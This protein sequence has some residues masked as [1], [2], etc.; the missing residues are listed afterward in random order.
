MA[1]SKNIDSRTTIEYDAEDIE[2]T[3]ANNN[4]IM[5]KRDAIEKLVNEI[6]T[7]EKN[8]DNNSIKKLI[9]LFQN[10]I[11]QIRKLASSALV[12]INKNVLNILD[13]TLY[14]TSFK[15]EDTLYWSLQTAAG[16][17]TASAEYVIKWASEEN[18]PKKYKPILAKTLSKINNTA[19][20]PF[21]IEL[22]G[23]DNWLTRKEAAA[24]LT[25][26]GRNI[27]PQL[28]SSFTNE[29][30]E[31]R[32]W[33]A[34]IIGQ[35]LG[36]D[37]FA[38]FKNM[39]QS[40]RRE[41]RYYAIS[42][43]SE[44]SEPDAYNAIASKVAD[45]SWLIRVQS[46]DILEKLGETAIPYLQKI[47]SEGTSDEKFYAIKILKNITKDNALRI[48]KESINTGDNDSKILMLS[49]LYDADEDTVFGMLADSLTDHNYFIQ[50]HASN[51]LIQMGC[52][53]L[54]KITELFKKTQNENLRYWLI[55]VLNSFAITDSFEAI[56]EIFNE[57][58]KRE[59]IQIL[60]PLSATFDIALDNK[61]ALFIIKALKDKS[62]SVRNCAFT[63]LVRFGYIKVNFNGQPESLNDIL[64]K[65]QDYGL[66]ESENEHIEE[67]VR[68]NALKLE[69]RPETK[70][71]AAYQNAPAAVTQKPIYTDQPQLSTPQANFYGQLQPASEQ[72]NFQTT[73]EL[74]I[75]KYNF[76]ID[77][78]LKDAISKKASDIHFSVNYPPSFRIDGNVEFQKKYPELTPGNTRYLAYQVMK[79]IIRNSFEKI[80]EL[81]ISYEIKGTARFRVN[82][83]MDMHG[84]GMVF[85]VIPY[86]IPSIETLGAPPILKTL[87][88]KSKGLVL[89]TG[90]TGSGKSTTLA[91]MIN[92]INKI[93]KAHII[94]IE[95]PVEFV[96]SPILSKITQRE[97]NVST[98]SF[99][100]ALRSSLRE[101][102]D[103]ILV[104]EMRDLE[105]IELAITA[106]ET[107]H[108][109]FG[110]V[111]TASAANTID[112]IIDVFPADKHSQVR[113]S[114]V[115]GLLAVIAQS[116][117]PKKNGHGR[118]AAFEV[119]TMTT[120][121][122]NL[123]KEGKTS[124]IKDY[125]LAGKQ[126][127]M[128]ILD[129]SLAELMTREEITFEDA[130]CAS[131]N[132]EDFKKR[133]G[134]NQANSQGGKVGI[135][136]ELS[137]EALYG[138]KSKPNNAVKP[139]KK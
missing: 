112:R 31:I 54:P 64:L 115:E 23:D 104:G 113:V 121:I 4:K 88:E 118:I 73:E 79:P 59:K 97:L 83:F 29:K 93:K 12:R 65:I 48:I 37:S 63:Q 35:I 90:P 8:S 130:L 14:K 18:F 117:V 132:K 5:S 7:L 51:L 85:R 6:R 68:S 96:H 45:P 127:G 106:A 50:K 74:E 43:L 133:Y 10:K 108:L 131:Y 116:L 38:F 103:I 58:Y 26:F 47:L 100:N 44:I 41:M 109:V 9:D 24:A 61:I 124:Q 33:I 107:G 81:D 28:Q 122:G 125:M 42:A 70:N 22:L 25:C 135:K 15:N 40:E 114:L 20:V 69:K 139:V 60:Q 101:D 72:F 128:Q 105:T 78:I 39:L 87:A 36:K 27:I 111:H 120:A 110:T 77:D 134:G 99:A 71:M 57:C 34:K 52:R 129:D 123:I 16:I 80:K 32:N 91:A 138:L 75:D 67:L 13:D 2:L 53:I 86:E 46:A 62:Y 3:Q 126:Y 56:T 137:N 102:P 136:D 82:I 92:Y 84:V 49:A 76:H 119:M 55:E 19:A 11:W 98:M 1:I 30:V 17:K 95:D 94:T 89:V 66:E 21:L